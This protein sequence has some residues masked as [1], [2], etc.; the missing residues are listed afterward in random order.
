[1]QVIPLTAVDSGQQAR[2]HQ[3]GQV[4]KP[5]AV[6]RERGIQL[7]PAFVMLLDGY[8]N[9]FREISPGGVTDRRLKHHISRVPVEVP[10]YRRQL[11]S[12][13]DEPLRG[14]KAFYDTL[15]FASSGASVVRRNEESG[16]GLV[17]ITLSYRSP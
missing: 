1:M 4:A 9:V 8:A 2:A 10:N 13:S 12:M 7:E 3:I 5:G 6:S 15:V 14:L 11:Y 17:R 16:Q